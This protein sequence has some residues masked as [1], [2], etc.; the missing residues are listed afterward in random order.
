MSRLDVVI[1]GAT[2]FTGKYAVIETIRLKKKYPEL[3]WGVA[4]RWFNQTNSSE[5]I[6][7]ITVIVADVKDESS[8]KTMCSQAKVLVNCCGPYR[9]YGEAVVRAAIES[10]SHYVDVSGEPQ[11]METMQLH[12]NEQAREA[13]VY[14]IGAC[15]FDSIPN[16][17]GLVYL[18]NNFKGTLNSVESYLSVRVSPEYEAEARKT[19]GLHYGTWESLVYGLAHSDELKPL[20][21]KLYPERLPTF[22]PKLE[23]RSIIHKRDGKWC[24]PFPGADESIVYRTQRTLYE[25]N[26]QRPAQFK[27]Y[28]RFS[29]LLQTLATMFVCIVMFLMSKTGFTRKLLLDYPRLFSLGLASHEGPSEP[30]MENTT[31]KFDLYGEGWEEG[32]DVDATPPN[33]KMAVKVSGKNPGYGATVTALML[34]AITILKEQNKMPSTGGVVTTGVAFKDT[35]LVKNLNENNVTFEII[36]SQ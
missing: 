17:L 35:D 11:F 30:V 23:K 19:G 6:S 9:W 25:N 26:Q 33:K 1:F 7:G 4:G 29:S 18:Q 13:G 5:D 12:Y 32:A 36:D 27:P 8:L 31:F 21:K 22:K 14:V 34:S 2:G 10:K 16:D 24:L 20:R 28:V 15:G 3:T